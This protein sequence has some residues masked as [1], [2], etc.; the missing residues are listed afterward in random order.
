MVQQHDGWKKRH[1]NKRVNGKIIG[2]LVLMLSILMLVSACSQSSA[3]QSSPQRV[4]LQSSWAEYYT[5]LKDLK[6]HSTIVVRGTISQFAL[7]VKPADG[8][9]YTPVSVSI[10]RVLWNP[11]NQ[12]APT[13]VSLVQTGGMYNNSIYQVDDD[14]LFQTGEQVILF[15]K[16]YQPG[17]FRIIGG[18][19]GRFKIVNST[20]TPIVSDGVKLPTTT[21]EAQFASDLQNA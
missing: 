21:N 5:S 6:Q 4:T 16:E 18:P 1:L 14:P 19:T 17:Q 13:S 9:V 12:T 11:H 20:A 7:A 10:T 15:L 3:S 8:P 2:G